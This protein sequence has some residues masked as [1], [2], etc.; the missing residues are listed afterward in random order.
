MT[1]PPRQFG[2]QGPTADPGGA[3]HDHAGLPHSDHQPHDHA[4]QDPHG[5]HQ[6]NG[7]GHRLMMLACCVPMLILVI[8]LVASGTAGSGA[9]VFA[10]L[11]IGM[12]GAMMFLMPGGGHRH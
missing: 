7:W 8:S 5:D 2:D 11:C 3:H 9:L 6:P 1:T 4:P 10:L 12:M